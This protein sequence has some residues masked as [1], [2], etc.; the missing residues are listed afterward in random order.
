M[1]DF[2]VLLKLRCQSNRAMICFL[3]IVRTRFNF[4]TPV[5]YA[6]LPSATSAYLRQTFIASGYVQR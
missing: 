1:I 5:G 4:F 6:I 2:W 3:Y